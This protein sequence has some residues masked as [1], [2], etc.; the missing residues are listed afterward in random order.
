MPTVLIKYWK[1][2][3]H[4]V[5]SG[6]KT[7][8]LLLLVLWCFSLKASGQ[9]EIKRADQ[10]VLVLKKPQL[11]YL[12]RKGFS[13]NDY[14]WKNKEVNY[15]LRNALSNRSSGSAMAVLGGVSGA[16]GLLLHALSG[17]ADFEEQHDKIIRSANGF[18]ITSAGFFT[19]SI[20]LSASGSKKVKSAEKLRS[21]SKPGFPIDYSSDLH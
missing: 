15:S 13:I 2:L 16:M 1:K 9:V 7:I 14:D 11:K 20:V 10:S 17:M 21:Q 5:S 4:L 8:V 19:L 3:Q 6:H 18:L 12:E